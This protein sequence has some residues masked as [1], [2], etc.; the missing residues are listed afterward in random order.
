M[1]FK[2]HFKQNLSLLKRIAG[3]C[4]VMSKVGVGIGNGTL[5]IIVI[6][7]IIVSGNLALPFLPSQNATASTVKPLY[8]ALELGA[9]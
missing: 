5:Y 9:E 2:T 8:W 7:M 3:P 4:T 1:L 6:L